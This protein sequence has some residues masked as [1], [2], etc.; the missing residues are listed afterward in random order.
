MIHGKRIC[1]GL[2]FAVFLPAAAAAGELAVPEAQ[3]VAVVDE[4][5]LGS[6]WA[7]AEG[8]T[9]TGAA[10]PAEFAG[11]GDDVCVAIGYR[12][13]ADGRTSDFSV[14]EQWSSAGN[15][16]EPVAGYWNA[17]AQSG[18]NAVSEWRFQPKSGFVGRDT[19]TVATVAFTGGGHAA[20]DVGA[21]CRVG[22]LASAI[23]ARQSRYFMDY[24]RERRDMD[25]SQRLSEKNRIRQAAARAAYR[26]QQP[27][28]QSPAGSQ[29]SG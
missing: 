14:L 15:R 9:I 6:R 7:L 24:S 12:I 17:F 8:A 19:Y 18:A 2:A 25:R 11:R 21:H 26:A 13:G 29:S 3:Q 28:P 5:G 27:Q 22:D 1:A 23:Q 20:A 4:G 16:G 10:Y